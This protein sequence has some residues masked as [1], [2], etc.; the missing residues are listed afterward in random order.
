MAQDRC[1]P[2]IPGD[3]STNQLQELHAKK[4]LRRVETGPKEVQGRTLACIFGPA[5]RIPCI[6][7]AYYH[8]DPASP[9]GKRIAKLISGWIGAL[10]SNLPSRTTPTIMTGFN[11]GGG[12]EDS[13]HSFIDFTLENQQQHY[14]TASFLAN[15]LFSSGDF[16][17]ANWP[18]VLRLGVYIAH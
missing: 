5:S 9:K 16:A 18:Y 6:T 7:A 2:D 14:R 17:L 11:G 8:P 3:I 15:A 10:I 12:Q 13:A 4:T 1:A